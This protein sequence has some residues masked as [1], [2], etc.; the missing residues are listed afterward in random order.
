MP[1]LVR[2]DSA[3]ITAGPSVKLEKPDYECHKDSM[4]SIYNLQ[5]DKT[6]KIPDINNWVNLMLNHY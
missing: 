4:V 2:P 1:I 3:F 5:Q 6:I